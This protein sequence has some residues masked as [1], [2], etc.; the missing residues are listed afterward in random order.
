MALSV[1]VGL[2]EGEDSYI[3]GV[4]ACQQAITNMGQGQPDAVILFASVKYD[5]EKVNAGVRSVS[6]NALLVGS[7]T[8]GEI[9]T[10]GPSTKHSVVVMALKSDSIKFYAGLGEN[11]AASPFDAG[12]QAGDNT[13]SQTKEPLRA[14]MMLSDVLA[15]NGADIVRGVLA[16]V[17]EHFPVV[18]GASGDDFQF[19]QTYQHLNDK[20]YSGVVIGFG[21]TG[22]F[23]LGIGVKHGW[24]PVGSPKKVTKSS[25]GVVHELDGKPAISIY[26][27]YFG[28]KEASVLRTETLAKLAVSYPLGM[29]VEGSD[30]MLIRDPLT[31]DENGSIT[32]AAEIPE[33][34]SIQLMIG[35][36]D[37]AIKVAGEA[38]RNA[39]EQL[40]GSKPKAV[41][42]FNCIARN[43]LFG[44]RSGDEIKEIQ[45]AVGP[46][47]PLIGF[48]T[49]GEQAPL[50]GEVR[51]IE[52]CNPAF[53][54]ET[55]VI[56]VMGE[57]NTA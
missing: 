26:D 45:K 19:K 34:S 48:Y 18:G 17:G 8:A 13:L 54:N 5:Q 46:D 4:N 7:S 28:E 16:S 51:N 47:T 10:A 24:V 27:E 3:V 11:I 21:W 29:K 15:G 42:I 9:T 6:G 30:E 43:K 44:E 22:D 35:S 37:E 12:K 20:V 14:F 49:Y 55:V 25:G 52:K 53:H 1:G 36:R 2:S 33:N 38:A 56:A 57:K 39:V 40:N 41:I 23:E 32:C 50:G 31:V